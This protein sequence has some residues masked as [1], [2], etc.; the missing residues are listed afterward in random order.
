[1]LHQVRLL[2]RAPP[3]QPEHVDQQALSEAMTAHHLL[4]ACE[5]RLRQRDPLAPVDVDKLV[6]SQPRQHPRDRGRL[7][8]QPVGHTRGDHL[9]ILVMG[10]TVDRRQRVVGCNVRD[11]LWHGASS[12]AILTLSHLDPQARTPPSTYDPCITSSE[13]RR[14]SGR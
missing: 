13:S 9:F 3:L 4:G 12:N 7:D 2:V 14:S 8:T 10:K 11:L 1:M 5:S 6:T